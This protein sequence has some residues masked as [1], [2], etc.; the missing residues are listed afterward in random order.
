MDGPPSQIGELK[1]ALYKKKGKTSVYRWDFLDR[2]SYPDGKWLACKYG[3]D[4]TLVLSR[5]IDDDATHCT[6]AH[7]KAWPAP[8]KIEVKCYW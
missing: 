3:D 2:D 5:R 6:V 7:T 4:H 1:E 8:D